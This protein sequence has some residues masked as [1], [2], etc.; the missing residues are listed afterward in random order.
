MAAPGVNDRG[1]VLGFVCI[2]RAECRALVSG[3]FQIIVI[4]PFFL[5]GYLTLP[6]EL[7]IICPEILKSSIHFIPNH[8]W[9]AISHSDSTQHS[10]FPF[11]FY[12]FQ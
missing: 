2:N 7:P 9:L 3:V 8:S 1:D 10:T 12:L 11:L 6:V 4:D 5:P